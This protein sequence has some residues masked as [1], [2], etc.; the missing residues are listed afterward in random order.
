MAN[1]KT[2]ELFIGTWEPS[3]ISDGH[4][5]FLRLNQCLLVRSSVLLVRRGSPSLTRSSQSS[6]RVRSSSCTAS[7]K[8]GSSV[9]VTRIN[10]ST[11][12]T[13]NTSRLQ[14]CESPIAFRRREEVG[15]TRALH[16]RFWFAGLLG[17]MLESKRVRALLNA[18]VLAAASQSDSSRVR[19]PASASFSFNPFP[20]IVIG[21]TG[22]AMSAHAQR[23][24]FQ[25][26]SRFFTFARKTGRLTV[27]LLV[28]SRSARALGT[29]TRWLRWFPPPH[30]L[31]PLPSTTTLD[32]VFA[33]TN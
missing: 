13:C 6:S 12:R 20:A 7:P 3:R 14:E 28:C 16:D 18:P 19:Q 15:L 27:H 1:D 2:N 9:L 24:I 30:L 26:K 32:P 4:G 25:G 29:P 17:M 21:V 10:P 5:T 31:L 8:C 23:Y 11:S 33:P 22:L